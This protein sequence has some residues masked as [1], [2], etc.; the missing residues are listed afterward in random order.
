MEDAASPPD[1]RATAPTSVFFSYSREDQDKAREL[2]KLID[3]AGFP[4]WWDGMLEG[5][6]RYSRATEDALERARAVVV[7]WTPVSVRSHWVH[8]EATRG[9]NREILV[10][11]AMEGVEP[12]LGFGQFQ[13]ITLPSGKLS[14]GLPA[15]ESLLKAIA[16]LHDAAAAPPPSSTTPTPGTNRAMIGRRAAIASGLALG[17]GALGFAGWKLVSPSPSS[18]NSIAVLPFENLSGDKAQQYFSDGLAA[19]IRAE[20]SRNILLETAGQTSSNQ[21]RAMQDDPRTIAG[22][23]KVAFLLQGNVQKMGDQLKVAT[24]LIDGKTGK[25]VWSEIYERE[26]SDVFQVQSEIA[27]AVT[28]KLSNAISARQSKDGAKQ[29]GGTDNLAAF[30][31]YLR[32]RDLFESHIDEASERAALMKFNEAIAL[33]PDYA[34]ARAARSRSLSIIANQYSGTTE[35]RALYAEAVAEAKRATELAPQLASGFAALGYAMFYGQLDARAARAP[36]DR[37]HALASSDVDVDFRYAVY[38]AR[39]GRHGEAAQAI[40]HAAALDPLN[41]SMFKSE[42]NIRYAAGDYEGAIVSTRKALSLSPERSTLH[43]DIGNALLML[44]R[45]DDA[46][47]AFDQERNTLL[48]LPGKA[49]VAIRKGDRAQANALL[50]EL[51]QAHGDN[52]LY[53]QAQILAQMGQADKALDVLE[54]AYSASDSGLVYLLNDPFLRPVHADLRYKGLLKKMRFV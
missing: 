1:S 34:A 49:I 39:T 11:L 14:R 19:E 9:R 40:A 31:A 22:K 3:E 4:T 37:A 38:C 51:Q 53:Q 16:A 41:A 36:Y 7:L 18:A 29:V 30:D 45:T 52:G 25:N 32:G 28:T 12:P 42:G 23:L 48:S 44:D 21:F 13:T 35:R 27:D 47:A 20:L 50:V 15:V 8:D 10:P 6:E 17:A 54:K 24:F 5:G 26:L 46:R 43:G 2:I 33:D